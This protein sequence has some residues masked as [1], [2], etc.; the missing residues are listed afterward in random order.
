MK[1]NKLKK[2]TFLVLAILLMIINMNS[3]SLAAFDDDVRGG[4]STSTSSESEKTAGDIVSGA[5]SFVT[6]GKGE[7]ESLISD[8]ELQKM[9]GMIYN[10]LLVFGI[11]IAIVIGM[12]LG[13]KFITS[14]VEGKAEVQQM[15]VPYVAGVLILA[16]AFTIWKIVVDILQSM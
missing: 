11:A 15:L 16:A 5:D 2:L 12:V 10:I 1:K 8:G 6:I 14:G 13:I 3:Y 4:G 9:S 7:G